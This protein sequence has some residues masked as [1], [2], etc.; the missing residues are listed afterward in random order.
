MGKKK[1]AMVVCGEFGY[2]LWSISC[3]LVDC[4]ASNS[5]LLF[6]GGVLLVFI[7]WYLLEYCCWLSNTQPQ[8]FI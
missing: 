1:P 4:G 3:S 7:D 2:F 8:Q 6:V 5:L